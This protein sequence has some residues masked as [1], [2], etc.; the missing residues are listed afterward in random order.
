MCST[1]RFCIM[2]CIMPAS[3]IASI[4]NLEMNRSDYK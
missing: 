3:A 2:I 1:M 4:E